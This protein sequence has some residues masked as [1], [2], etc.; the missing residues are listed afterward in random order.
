MRLRAPLLLVMLALPLLLAAQE[1]LRPAQRSELWAA[2]AMTGRLPLFLKNALGDSYKH[3][4]VRNELGYRSTDAFFAGRQFY[5]DMNL[6]YRLAKNVH[7]AYEHRFAKRPNEAGLRNRSIV[8]LE[9]EKGLGRFDLGY[10]GLWQHGYIDW[11]GQRE[12]FRNKFEA[13]YRFRNWKLDP[14]M[15][16][17]FFNWAS[18]KGWSYFGTRWQFGT[19]YKLSKAQSISL[20]LVHDRE[21]DIAWPTYRWITSI[22]YSIDLRDL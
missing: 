18:N 10:R 22:T 20:A 9:I 15:S 11:G 13:T 16:V 5:L 17:E 2:A 19:E 6:R 21:R 8:Q 3:F 4:R 12:V 1:A 14:R 7:L